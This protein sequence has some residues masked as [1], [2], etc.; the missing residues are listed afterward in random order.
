[1]ANL[2]V[3]NIPHHFHV[4]LKLRARRHRR[5]VNGELL[6]ILEE[7]LEEESEEDAKESTERWRT[8]R[9]RCLGT[10]STEEVQAAIKG[11]RA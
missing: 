8:L 2:L 3:R 9:S 11:G 1:M 4:R 5:S 7:V 10:M 6:S